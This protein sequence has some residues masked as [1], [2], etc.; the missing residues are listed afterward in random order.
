VQIYLAADN[1]PN[2]APG[3]H[4]TAGA[5]GSLE[6]RHGKARES[7][8]SAWRNHCSKTAGLNALE[9]HMRL[10]RVVICAFGDYLRHRLQEKAIHLYCCFEGQDKVRAYN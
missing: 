9:K 1:K 6:S 2:L 7:R 10:R 5:E 3:P 8:F 4:W